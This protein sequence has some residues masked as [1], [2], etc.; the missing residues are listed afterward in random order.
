VKFT[1]YCGTG[2]LIEPAPQDNPDRTREDKTSHHLTLHHKQPKNLILVGHNCG[3][4]TNKKEEV[5]VKS[6]HDIIVKVLH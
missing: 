2:A 6:T 3:I 5:H 4:L 1:L